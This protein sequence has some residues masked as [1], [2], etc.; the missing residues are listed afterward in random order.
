L[1]AAITANVQD[2]ALRAHVA[3]GL[4]GYSRADFILQDDGALFLLEVNTIPGMT[5]TSL[6]PR[7]AAVI[8][9]SFADLAERLLQLAVGKE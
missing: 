4:K 7:E 9:L 3:L 6:V 1:S 8:G 5:A 2:C